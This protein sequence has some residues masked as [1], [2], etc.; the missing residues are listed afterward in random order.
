MLTPLSAHLAYLQILVMTLT[1]MVLL[2][3]HN[4]T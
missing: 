1:K 4:F 2:A 3:H